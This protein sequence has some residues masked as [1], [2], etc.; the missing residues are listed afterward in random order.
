V[1]CIV[2]KSAL[3]R[4]EEFTRRHRIRIRDFETWIVSKEDLILSKLVWA[5]D[6]ESER[7]LRDVQNLIASGCDA[8]II[9]RWTEEL[10]VTSLWQSCRA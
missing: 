2:R 8:A 9:E 5:R 10:Q 4:R 1:D 6:S 3:Y 7:Q